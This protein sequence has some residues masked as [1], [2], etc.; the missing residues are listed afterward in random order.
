MFDDG[1]LSKQE[2]AYRLIRGRIES[3]AFRPGQ[4]L[5][6]DSLSRDLQISS[7]PIREAIRK[8]E[9]EGWV[10]YQR[11]A[12]PIVANVTREQWQANQEILAVLHGYATGLASPLLGAG[13]IK[14]LRQINRRM[15]RALESFDS[16]GFGACNQQFHET[17]YRECTNPV[18]VKEIV[19]MQARIDAIK[20]T[21][22]SSLPHRGRTEIDEHN[23]LID[24]I[25]WHEPPRAIEEF[26][27]QHKLGF[28]TA[29]LE[30]LTPAGEEPVAPSGR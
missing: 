12:G 25:E 23:R 21:V 17:I 13:S 8:L 20:G 2:Q 1:G 5:V 27:R 22:Y 15:L 3:S 16:A 11:N 19:E 28:L 10:H 9:A 30:H 7:V 18:L 4:R 26:A 29:A 6:I 14:E 24:M